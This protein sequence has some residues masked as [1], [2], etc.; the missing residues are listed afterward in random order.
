MEEMA[1]N[2]IMWVVAKNPHVAALIVMMGTLRLVLK[3][4]MSA[5]KEVIDLTPTKWDNEQFDK[6]I[7]SKAYKAVSWVLDYVGSVKLPKAPESK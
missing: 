2:F 6:L 4:I 5:L 3:P 1:L 7:N